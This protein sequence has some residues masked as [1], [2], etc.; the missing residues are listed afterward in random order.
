MHMRIYAHFKQKAL[1]PDEDLEAGGVDPRQDAGAD[2]M[3]GRRVREGCDPE[4]LEQFAFHNLVRMALAARV[5]GVSGRHF[6]QTS[7]KLL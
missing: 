3:G 6:Q 5:E 2:R 1:I 7:P 4:E